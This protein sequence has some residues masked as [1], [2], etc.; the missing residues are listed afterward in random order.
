MLAG[1]ASGRPLRQVADEMGI[2]IQT[3]TTH[4]REVYRKLNVH[5]AVQAAKLAMNMKLG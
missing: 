1:I 5:T 2:S 3:F 4:R